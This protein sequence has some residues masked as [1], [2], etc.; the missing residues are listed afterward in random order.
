VGPA[1]THGNHVLPRWLTDHLRENY[2]ANL[3]FD[4]LFALGVQVKFGALCMQH[5]RDIVQSLT[6][7]DWIERAARP[8]GKVIV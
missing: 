5:Q 2:T 4:E 1:A 6:L 7:Y 3:L 8:F